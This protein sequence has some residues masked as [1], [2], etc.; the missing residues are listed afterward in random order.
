M[1]KLGVGVKP[2]PLQS[3]RNLLN[4]NS[5]IWKSE[6]EVQELGPR[7]SKGRNRK[8]KITK[9]ARSTAP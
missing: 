1:N 7:A 4:S 8:V 3:L 5:V 6:A 9:K 2:S